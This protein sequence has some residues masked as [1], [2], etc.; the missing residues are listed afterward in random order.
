M[1]KLNN[2]LR[3]AMLLAALAGAVAATAADAGER[4]WADAL[5]AWRAERD[6]SLRADDGWL[7]LAGLFWLKE[8][9]SSVGSA[10]GSDVVLPDSAPARAARLELRAG[11]VVYTLEPGGSGATLQGAPA[12]DSGELRPDTEDGGPSLLAFGPVSLHLIV[13]GGRH[14]VR[15]KDRDSA[16]RRGFKGREWYAADAAWRVPARFVPHARA[17]TLRVPNVLGQVTEMES[18]GEVVFTVAGRELRLTPVLEEPDS[19][20]LFFIFKDGTSGHGTYPAGRF[21]Y[22]PL[23]KDG[24]VTLDFNRA[25]NPP[26]AFTPYATCPLPPEGNRLTAAIPAGEKAGAHP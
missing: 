24:R 15:V 17:T 26:C 2:G 14:G 9:V 12:P 7:T 22:T 19:D 4:A 20:E 13:R 25:V 10:P 21:L 8:G 23:P 11:R 1:S 6:A 18:P 5:A 3:A 16:A